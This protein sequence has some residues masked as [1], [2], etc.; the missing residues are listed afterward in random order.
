MKDP[1]TVIDTNLDHSISK[2]NGSYSHQSHINEKEVN[3]DGVD[4]CKIQ[5]SFSKYHWAKDTPDSRDYKYKLSSKSQINNIDLRQYCSNIENQGNLGSCTGNAVAGAIELFYKKNNKTID[6]SRLFIY[7]YS[8]FFINMINVDSGAR[9][10]DAIKSV[11]TY[12]APLESLWPYNIER[13]KVK[14]NSLAVKDG[15]QRKVNLYERIE[16]HEGCL[17]AITNG[18][19]VV[20]GFNVYSSF[21]SPSVYSRGLM[22]YPNV[23]KERYLGGH[24]V[25]LV[26]YDKRSQYY[27]AR[28]SWGTEWGDNG[29]F[30]MPFKVIQ[31]RKMSDD[32]WIIKSVKLK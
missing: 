31:D 6:V 16:G 25:L 22:E 19:P 24:A 10:R 12:G 28:N 7:Y 13:F 32:F 15:A 14:P 1:R 23:S 27:I 20:I 3:L 11:H 2:F 5:N 8:R 9:I 17:D 26:G 4:L 29:Y 18:Y 21:E 30:Y